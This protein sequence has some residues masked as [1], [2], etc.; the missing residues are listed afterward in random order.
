MILYFQVITKILDFFQVAWSGCLP[1]LLNLFFFSSSYLAVK[2][3]FLGGISAIILDCMQ[4][5]AE[6]PHHLHTTEWEDIQYQFGNRVGKYETHEEEI[7]FRKAAQAPEY[8][9][10]N[11]KAYNP[12]EEKK[13]DQSLR[14]TDTETPKSQPVDQESEEDENDMLLR[15]RAQRLEE[16]KQKVSVNRFGVL[17]SIP[18]SDYVKEV[19]EASV[20]SWVVALLVQPGASEC[21][22]LLTAMRTV[23]QRNK[24]VKF[25]SMVFTEAVNGSFPVHHL[26]CVLLYHQGK[27]QQQLTGPDPWKTRRETNVEKVEKTLRQYGVLPTVETSGDDDDA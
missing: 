20:E 26:P 21:E 15:I 2:N 3:I 10:R 23:A 27:L 11:L 12:E 18:G 7:L 17:R 9:N 14:Q 4:R 25:V 1:F 16:L 24:F 22:A 8:L 5:T 6:N 19:T 13:I